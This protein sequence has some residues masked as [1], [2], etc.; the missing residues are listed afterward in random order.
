M[1]VDKDDLFLG[2]IGIGIILCSPFILSFYAG[3]WIYGHTPWKLKKKK[4]LDKEI[5]LLEEKLGLYGRN[6]KVL[7]YD[8]LYFR[9]NLGD[10]KD[11]CKD[12]KKKLE[13]G[14]VS[15]PI[16]IAITYAPPIHSFI[17]SNTIYDVVLLVHKDY[18]YIPK[19]S[20]RA[21]TYFGQGKSNVH[22]KGQLPKPQHRYIHA[23][24][25]A[26]CGHYEN[27]YIVEVPGGY[28]YN[29]IQSSRVIREFIENF[30]NKYKK[31]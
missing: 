23:Q 27:Y 5:H 20:E 11:Y 17:P 4:E 21:D 13:K 22:K 1:K 24:T 9:N 12:L 6:N 3:K 16:I 15:P 28:E 19:E 29:E 26:E 2:A 18:Y 10:R 30:K 8:P 25:R 31:E 7:H 14:Y